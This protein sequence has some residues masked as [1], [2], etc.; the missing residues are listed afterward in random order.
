[1]KER[2]KALRKDM[3]KRLS[4]LT[5]DVRA[6]ETEQIRQQLFATDQWKQAATIG[7]TVSRGNEIDTY[8]IIEKAWSEG[9]T[10]AV[11]K[12]H[13]KD[14]SMDFRKLE[15][16][17][18][19]EVVYFGLRE[20][21]VEKTTQIEPNE[22]GLLIVPGLLFDKSGYRVGFGGGFYD[23]YLDRFT[24]TT[25]SLLHSVQLH[26]EIPRE[27]FDQPVDFLIFPDRVHQ[28]KGF[29]NDHS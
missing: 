7:V 19:L 20:P 3:Q 26:D 14:Y 21:I 27:S 24:G 23:R 16:F 18:Q 5:P 28:T 17:D 10:V 29:R 13:A 9:K 6:N 15:S 2:K 4:E 8:P 1:M 22:M 25:V 12:C 11:P